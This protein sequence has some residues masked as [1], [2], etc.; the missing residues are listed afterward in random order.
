MLMWKV[1]ADQDD[2]L[3]GGTE[4][5]ARAYIAVHLP[6]CLDAVLESPD[7]DSYGYQDGIWVSLD[8]FGIWPGQD[9]GHLESRWP[10]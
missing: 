6:E 1:W 7:G 9:L 8:L 2:P 4:E 3:F 10:G 5:E